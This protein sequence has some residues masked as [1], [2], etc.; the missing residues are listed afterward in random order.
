MT[1]ASP[2]DPKNATSATGFSVVRVSLMV[3]RWI[4][5]V[6]MVVYAIGGVIFGSIGLVTQGLAGLFNT[7]AGALWASTFGRNSFDLFAVFFERKLTLG[8]AGYPVGG[9]QL[10]WWW[11][12]PAFEQAPIFWLGFA[13][14]WAAV[15]VLMGYILQSMSPA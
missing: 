2:I 10:W 14:I 15:W 12:R 5:T 13:V 3:L 8:I 9:D 7:P 1:S 11:L 4:A 6:P